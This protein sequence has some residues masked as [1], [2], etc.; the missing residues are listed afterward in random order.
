MQTQS[1][2]PPFTSILVN[3]LAI[4]CHHIRVMLVSHCQIYLKILSISL[5]G[6]HWMVVRVF[7]VEI[8]D[9]VPPSQT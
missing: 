3:P 8:H 1:I 7:Q 5:I 4:M 2:A 9:C 6:N